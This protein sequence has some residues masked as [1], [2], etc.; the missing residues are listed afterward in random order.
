LGK[1]KS[2]QVEEDKE[3][4]KYTVSV[5]DQIMSLTG[6]DIG[7]GIGYP[8]RPSQ[9]KVIS[10]KLGGRGL[11]ERKTLSHSESSGSIMWSGIRV[12]PIYPC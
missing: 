7:E 5:M 12:R 8:T 3:L 6:K 2:L 9:L 11:G 4:T 10:S 1:P